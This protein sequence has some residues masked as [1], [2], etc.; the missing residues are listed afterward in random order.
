M[1]IMFKTF[2]A[3]LL[4]LATLAPAQASPII[5]DFAYEFATGEVVSGELVG[6]LQPDMDTVLVSELLSA[7]FTGRPGALFHTEVLPDMNVAT[8]S[9]VG[10]SFSTG[11]PPPG[12]LGFMLPLEQFD[13]L[14]IVIENT[15]ILAAMET[16]APERWRMV[17][18]EVPLPSSIALVI[19]GLIGFSARALTGQGKLLY[20][21][22]A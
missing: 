8:I 2:L 21:H 18:Q 12:L 1:A 5:F 22:P 19:V 6:E 17:A 11:A 7:M 20:R 15:H 3:T 13:G 4:A 10:G 14:A 9:G 16:F